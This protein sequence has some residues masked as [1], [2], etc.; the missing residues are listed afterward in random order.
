M[1]PND[2][3]TVIKEATNTFGDTAVK[4]NDNGMYRMNRTLLPILLK[5]PYD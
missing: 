2:I 4:P 5:I 1:T 3:L